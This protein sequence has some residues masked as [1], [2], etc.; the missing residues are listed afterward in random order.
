MTSFFVAKH[1]IGKGNS[2]ANDDP[3]GKTISWLIVAVHH[4][5]KAHHNGQ[6]QGKP[7]QRLDEHGSTQSANAKRGQ[8]VG[9]R[10]CLT[11]FVPHHLRGFRSKVNIPKPAMLKTATSIIVSSARKS[12]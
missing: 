10:P 9:K 8:V 11:H 1:D 2:Q 12:Q 3:G 7:C 4:V 6:R 5:G